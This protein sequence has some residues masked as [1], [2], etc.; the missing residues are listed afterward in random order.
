[1][2]DLLRVE[3]FCLLVCLV[4]AGKS[5][6]E[7]LVRGI[8]HLN[9]EVQFMCNLS[10]DVLERG[11]QKGYQEGFHMGVVFSLRNLMKNMTLTKEQ[12]MEALGIPESEREEYAKELIKE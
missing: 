10:K 5:R 8:E 4:W 2:H 7:L 1:M 11:Y 9:R 6:K 12:A 3:T